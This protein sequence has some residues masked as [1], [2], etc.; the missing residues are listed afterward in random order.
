VLRARN[1]TLDDHAAALAGRDVE[2]GLHGG[3]PFQA[4]GNP[5]PVVRVLRLDHDGQA[6]ILGR[7]PRVP[8]TCDLAPRGHGH[9]DRRDELARQLLVL[10]DGFGQGAGLGGFGRPDAAL[11]LAIPELHE[12]ARAHAQRRDQPRLG[13]SDDGLR[14]RAEAA[15]V[16][17]LA[18]AAQLARHVEWHV[19][20]G[21]KQQLAAFAQAGLA[22]AVLQAFDDNAI[23]AA[24][25]G[26]ARAAVADRQVG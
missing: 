19:L 26:F 15:A 17:H 9:A 13:G 24:L 18:Q 4:N 16:G 21:G 23:D 3:P 10:R 1:E 25:A 5:A 12:V 6:Q 2:G 14:A 20:D 11:G 8:P 22:E 7:G